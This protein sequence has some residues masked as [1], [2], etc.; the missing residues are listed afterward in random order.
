MIRSS[1]TIAGVVAALLIATAHGGTDTEIQPLLEA[2]LAGD[3]DAQIALAR[4][5]EEGRG[6][7]RDIVGA[8]IWYCIAATDEPR[9]RLDCDRVGRELT[10]YQSEHMLQ[11]WAE[12]MPRPP[13][14]P[15]RVPPK[16]P[17]VLTPEIT[18]PQ[19]VHRVAPEYP[20]IAR[21]A[22]MEGNVIVQIV[23]EADGMVS[24]VTVLSASNPVFV[25]NAVAAVKQWQYLP[26]MQDDEP[27][28]VYVTFE[29][30]FL[31]R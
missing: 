27:V 16:A 14:D 8:C 21:S 30:E 29:V 28:A 1:G 6:V 19:F 31:L 4:L 3:T 20:E 25:E 10:P 13:E 17:I 9:A 11:R 18:P 22:Q 15:S 7:R 12:E 5:Y 26:A 24:G 2:A 23:I